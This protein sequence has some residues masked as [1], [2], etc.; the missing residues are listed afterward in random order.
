MQKRTSRAVG[1]VNLSERQYEFAERY[2]KDESLRARIGA[3][4]PEETLSLLGIDPPENMETRIVENTE[5][6]V[7]FV[8][9]SDPNAQLSDES[10]S[11]VTGGST[12]GSI[13]TLT[14]FGSFPSCLGS[15]GTA[16]TLSSAES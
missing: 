1:N 11:T 15:A 16:S 14:T 2:Y 6:T 5:D 9:P 8:F 13:G 4:N 3:A 10:L 7:Y 12:A